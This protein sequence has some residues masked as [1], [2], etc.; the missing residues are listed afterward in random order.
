MM[1]R[2]FLR[3]PRL[4]ICLSD[5]LRF[6]TLHTQKPTRTQ[7]FSGWLLGSAAFGVLGKL[8]CWSR[9]L[10]SHGA[11]QGWMWAS[12]PALTYTHDGSEATL[13]SY[14]RTGICSAKPVIQAQQSANHEPILRFLSTMVG[15]RCDVAPRSINN[16]AT[17]SLRQLIARRSGVCPLLSFAPIAAPQSSKVLAIP[18]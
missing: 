15:S 5:C 10:A 11:R 4:S 13:T 12:K 7:H 16:F 6:L 3:V 14:G 2:A 8:I 17:M 18:T 1:A 9:H